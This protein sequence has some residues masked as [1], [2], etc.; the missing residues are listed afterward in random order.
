MW[1]GVKKH[2]IVHFKSVQFTISQ[3]YQKNNHKGGKKE[4]KSILLLWA[5]KSNKDKFR[6]TPT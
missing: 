1:V 3:S 2:Q 5:E 6:G 4:Y